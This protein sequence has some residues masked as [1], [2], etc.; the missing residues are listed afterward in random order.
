M[1]HLKKIEDILMFL[2]S[3]FFVA[4]ERSNIVTYKWLAYIAKY[5]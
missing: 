1:N 2:V 3:G 4:P 5:P